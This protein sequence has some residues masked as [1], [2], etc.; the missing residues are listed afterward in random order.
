MAC[1]LMRT[2]TRL[3]WLHETRIAAPASAAAWVL[4]Q[5][6]RPLALVMVQPPNRRGGSCSSSYRS[7]KSTRKENLP[8]SVGSRDQS[9]NPTLIKTAKVPRQSLASP[10][11]PFQLH[12]ARTR[13]RRRQRGRR[14][15]SV[16]KWSR[17]YDAA[18]AAPRDSNRQ[19]SSCAVARVLERP[20]KSPPETSNK[21]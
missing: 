9:I 10:R 11:V 7:F 15:H 5:T 19:K 1:L 21:E 20:C 8:Q 3:S 2:R 18:G 6:R 17:C 13:L 4:P 14:R 12:R 16:R